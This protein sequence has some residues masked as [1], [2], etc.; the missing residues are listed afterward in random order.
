MQDIET[1]T[2]TEALAL[3]EELA[4]SQEYN[5]RL[6]EIITRLKGEVT[7][8]NAVRR[9]LLEKDRAIEKR[10]ARI[11]V[12]ETENAQLKQELRNMRR[13]PKTYNDVLRELTAVRARLAK[14]EAQQV[15]LRQALSL[16]ELSAAVGGG[17]E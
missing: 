11:K 13:A 3:R 2:Y 10:N 6:L 15:A 9:Q 7:D 12:L 4:S 17:G 14:E 16:Y 8:T 1:L 5:A